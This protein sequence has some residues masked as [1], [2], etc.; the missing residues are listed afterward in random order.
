MPCLRLLAR[1]V[2]HRAATL[3]LL[4]GAVSGAILCPLPALAQ[5]TGLWLEQPNPPNPP[6]PLDPPDQLTAA[7]VPGAPTP[8][9]PLD[10]ASTV[11]ALPAIR[12]FD[13]YLPYRAPGVAAWGQTNAAVTPAPRA[14]PPSASSMPSMPRTAPEPSGPPVDGATHHHH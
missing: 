3:V 1:G 9:S 12:A 14:A 6:D 4:A 7:N 5:T 11:P 8:P 13:G 10:P 2:A